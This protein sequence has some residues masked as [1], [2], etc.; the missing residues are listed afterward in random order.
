MWDV[1]LRPV[2]RGWYQKILFSTGSLPSPVDQPTVTIPGDDPD[3]ILLLGNGPACG[4]GVTSHELALTGQLAREAHRGTGRPASVHFI[5]HEMMNVASTVAWLGDHDL[6]VYDAIVVMIGLNDA[7]RLTPDDVWRRRLTGLL[8]T[9]RL[10]SKWSTKIIVAGIP[11]VRSIT[12]FDCFLGGIAEKHAARL[13]TITEDVVSGRY[14][15]TFYPLEPV[16]FVA[17]RPFGSAETYRK[18]AVTLT[19]QLIPALQQARD[20]E[21]EVREVNPQV[22]KSW[23]WSGA[24]TFVKNA[25]CGGSEVLKTL[26]AEAERAFG[27][28]L[29]VVTLLDGS[30]LWYGVHTNLLPQPAPRELTYCDIAAASDGPLIVSDSRADPRFRENPFIDISGS[31]FYAGH[32]LHA[33]S[34]DTIGTFCLHN[35]KPK[36]ASSIRLDSLASFARRAEMELRSY[37]EPRPGV[38]RSAPGGAHLRTLPAKRG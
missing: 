30:T 13:N 18:R 3:R 25:A 5:G 16:V 38:T 15:T 33:T 8:N 24:E 1:V 37:E 21:L 11:P 31:R 9:L 19:D 27:V 14:G 23:E 6:Q 2:M 4:W 26:T 17:D 34:G 20:E 22:G 32:P 35:L 7:V 29:A 12:A 28:D 36:P 10:R